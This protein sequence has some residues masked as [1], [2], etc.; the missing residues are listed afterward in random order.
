MFQSELDMN[1]IFFTFCKY[2]ILIVYSYI[3]KSWTSS[4][5][6]WF[7]LLKNTSLPKHQV[8]LALW[9]STSALSLNLPILDQSPSPFPR[10]SPSPV[11]YLLCSCL[12][13]RCLVSLRIT[14]LA[15]FSV[16]P[17]LLN[18]WITPEWQNFPDTLHSPSHDSL[19]YVWC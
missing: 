13:Y 14:V 6:T 17:F 9:V 19:I 8:N 7:P 12:L 10:L 18:S 16:H 11:P 4:Y 3:K 15:H 2:I 1:V 5:V